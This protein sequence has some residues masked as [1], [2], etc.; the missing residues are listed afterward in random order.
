MRLPDQHLWSGGDPQSDRHQHTA[1]APPCRKKARTGIAADVDKYA[2]AIQRAV[3]VSIP[4]RAGNSSLSRTTGLLGDGVVSGRMWTA[5]AAWPEPFTSRVCA[6]LTIP[7]FGVAFSGASGRSAAAAGGPNPNVEPRDHKG[8]LHELLARRFDPR[9][10]PLGHLPEH[11]L[12]VQSEMTV[13]PATVSKSRRQRFLSGA[14]FGD[15]VVTHALSSIAGIISAIGD[16]GAFWRPAH[17][18][19][20][21]KPKR[22]ERPAELASARS[23]ACCL[24][25]TG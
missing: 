5:P 20:A 23:H 7:A 25:P 3:S 4:Q 17:G 13:S 2:A 16:P 8:R 15:F 19:R 9:D 11:W 22:V 14:C 12:M 18:A 1:T 21:R 6:A 10:F 24:R